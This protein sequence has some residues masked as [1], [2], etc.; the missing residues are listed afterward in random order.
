VNGRAGIG[1]LGAVSGP[2]LAIASLAV[3]LLPVISWAMGRKET[4]T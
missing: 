2:D 1:L 4:T 3:A